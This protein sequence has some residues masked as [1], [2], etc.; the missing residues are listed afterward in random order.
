MCPCAHSGGVFETCQ[1]I[2]GAD[3]LIRLGKNNLVDQCPRTALTLH[4]LHT[5]DLFFHL[6]DSDSVNGTWK[7]IASAW[8][9][10]TLPFSVSEGFRAIADELAEI[11][12]EKRES[13][14]KGAA[15]KM[16]TFNKGMKR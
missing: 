12:A 16:P 13:S 10:M 15:A 1:H 11:A 2:G 9:R 4:N 6:Y 7:S 3:R 8:E 14:Q 5:I